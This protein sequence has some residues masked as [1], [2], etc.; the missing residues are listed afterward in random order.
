MRE[1][2]KC[3]KSLPMELFPKVK[4]AKDGISRRCQPCLKQSK[5]VWR[6]S[7]REHITKYNSDYAKDNPE[8][9]RVKKRLNAIRN[10]STI[11]ARAARRRAAQLQRTTAWSDPDAI[12]AIYA[13]AAELTIAT[14]IQFH[15]DHIVPLQGKTV[16][17]LHVESN[18]QVLPWYENLSKSNNF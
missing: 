15:V 6:S 11:N 9:T 1:C 4:A 3:G 8:S 7:N 5:D 2:K 13:E 18:L 14:G 10:P 12:R 17:G 16:S